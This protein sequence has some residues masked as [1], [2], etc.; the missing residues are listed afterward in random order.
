M[1]SNKQRIRFP[2]QLKSRLYREQR[3]RC[4]YCGFTHQM[5][6]LEIDH[7]YPLSRGGGNEIN[8]L[9]LL[10][11]R[12]N[13]RKGIQSDGEF[14]RR[15]H[16][17][18]PAD[19]GIPSDP[20]S[21]VMFSDETQRTRAPSEVRSIFHE[22]FTAYRARQRAKSS[23]EARTVRHRR[24]GERRVSQSSGCVLHLATLALVTVGLSLLVLAY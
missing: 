7:K 14:R 13:M 11:T 18:L 16:R 17:L 19:E 1:N 12:C 4:S 23:R 24:L 2:R 5:G 22:R 8:N 20:I 21:Q 15:Y 10:C 9:Q 3:G 6:Y